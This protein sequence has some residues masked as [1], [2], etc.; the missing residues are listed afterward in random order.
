MSLNFGA[1]E[2]SLNAISSVTNWCRWNRETECREWIRPSGLVV[3]F[4]SSEKL[5]PR[6]SFRQS[7]AGRFIQVIELVPF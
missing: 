6:H 5:R 7:R 3:D 2:P 1:P 4:M